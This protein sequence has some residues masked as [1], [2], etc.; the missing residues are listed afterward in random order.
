[1]CGGGLAMRFSSNLE[2]KVEEKYSLGD[3]EG[4]DVLGTGILIE[5]FLDDGNIQRRWIN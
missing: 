3:E 1:M 5:C 2:I 4:G